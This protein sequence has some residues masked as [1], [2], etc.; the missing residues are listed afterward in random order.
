[1]TIL[2]FAPPRLNRRDFQQHHL[3]PV[4]VLNRRS[5]S[6]L[7]S[8][9]IDQGFEPHDFAT[10]GILLPSTETAARACGLPLHRGPH[11]RYNALISDRIGAFLCG[12]DAATARSS[13]LHRIRFLQAGIRRSLITGKP[14]V[15]LNRRD[16]TCMIGEIQELDHM[17]SGSNRIL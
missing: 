12:D 14:P 13:T 8:R 9:L 15:L 11:P 7:F 6:S 10:N 16:P 5:F 3:I 17:I 2:Q 4:E 1:M